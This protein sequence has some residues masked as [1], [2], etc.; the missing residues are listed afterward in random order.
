MRTDAELRA[1]IAGYARTI[2]TSRRMVTVSDKRI[3]T[4][5]QRVRDEQ[6]VRSAYEMQIRAEEAAIRTADWELT[7][8]HR[9][10][11]H[12]HCERQHCAICEG[13]LTVCTVCGAL[14]GALLPTCPKRPL[15][16]A[17]HSA[18]YAHY[19]AGTGPF[20]S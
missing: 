2:A 18:N 14:E 10:E 19:C 15:T 17:E 8:G 11:L 20:A 4:L 7:T 3:A 1:T 6:A 9:V 5:E 12:E 13:G 16:Y